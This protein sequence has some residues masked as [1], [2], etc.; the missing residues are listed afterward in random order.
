LTGF[1][2]I[3]TDQTTAKNWGQTPIKELPI[4]LPQRTQR[5][6]GDGTPNEILTQR[7]DFVRTA[8]Q[9]AT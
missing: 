8:A 5:T 6:A 7:A 3:W 2:G 9:E 4:A 1:D